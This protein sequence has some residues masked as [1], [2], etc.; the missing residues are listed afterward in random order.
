MLKA[1]DKMKTT[2][3]GPLMDDLVHLAPV[4]ANLRVIGTTQCTLPFQEQ[5]AAI[6]WLT[7]NSFVSVTIKP[8]FRTYFGP[9][10]G[11]IPLSSFPDEISEFAA[12]AYR[13]T[14]LAREA[15]HRENYILR[16][17]A[18]DKRTRVLVTSKSIEQQELE[19]MK[20]LLDKRP[21]SDRIPRKSK[22]L[23]NEPGLEGSKS[24]TDDAP[25][26]R[27]K[28]TP[29]TPKETEGGVPPETTPGND[30]ATDGLD[31]RQAEKRKRGSD[32]T[33]DTGGTE[34]EDAPLKP[35]P[36]NEHGSVGWDYRHAGKKTTDSATKD[37]TSEAESPGVM[38]RSGR[39]GGCR[40]EVP[41]K[42]PP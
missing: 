28:E 14:V 37:S 21:T 38:T 19:K 26:K 32:A 24:N 20:Q 8:A 9:F 42:K 40:E 12:A 25:A 4:I 5:L 18:I 10:K 2:G 16:Q 23:G 31:D 11:P 39:G 30:C 17:E 35:A 34:S 36:E 15:E 3:R 33:G 6:R 27:L 29:T 41:K 13:D 7:D 22:T 1:P